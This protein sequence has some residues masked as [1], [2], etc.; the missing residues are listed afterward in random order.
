MPTDKSNTECTEMVILGKQEDFMKIF[1]LE[2]ATLK[3]IA[4]PL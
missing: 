1:Y 3:P 4:Y 2:K